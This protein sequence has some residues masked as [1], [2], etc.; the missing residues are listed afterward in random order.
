MSNIVEKGLSHVLLASK[1]ATWPRRRLT[2]SDI[3]LGFWGNLEGIHGLAGATLPLFMKALSKS[4][5]D[6][7]VQGSGPA[8]A[9]SFLD[10]ALVEYSGGDASSQWASLSA[11][12]SAGAAGAAAGAGA[13]DDSGHAARNA[14]VRETASSW[15]ASDSM[16]DIMLLRSAMQPLTNMLAT[17]LDI[18]EASFR[19]P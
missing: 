19:R 11:H 10:G 9:D 6:T 8:G 1:P 18:K 16:G 13:A 14:K 3:A 12:P 15:L 7:A 17:Q 5:R 4:G 2:G